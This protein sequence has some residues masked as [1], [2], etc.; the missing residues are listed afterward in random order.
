MMNRHTNS[1]ILVQSKMI[2]FGPPDS[3]KVPPREI[4]K[5]PPKVMVWAIMSC[6]ALSELH[7]VPPKQMVTSQYYVEEVLEKSCRSAKS[8]SMKTGYSDHEITPK[9][10]TR[11][12][13][14]RRCSSTH[15]IAHSNGIVTTFPLSGP[16]GN[17]LATHRI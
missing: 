15:L 5:K 9:H 13:H 1:S 8:R 11:H 14:A 17:G 3:S 12:F 6:R 10:V 2:E 7:F 16:K 4:I